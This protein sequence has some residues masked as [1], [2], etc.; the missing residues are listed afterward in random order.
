MGTSFNFQKCTDMQAGLIIEAPPLLHSFPFSLRSASPLSMST[1]LPSPDQEQMIDEEAETLRTELGA[2]VRQKDTKFERK[3][4]T[5]EE[6]IDESRW[7]H[8]G[9][10]RRKVGL[11]KKVWRE[12]D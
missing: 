4:E 9:P 7:I 11:Q 6:C 1:I 12:I 8:V 3:M 10:F 2:W 5:L